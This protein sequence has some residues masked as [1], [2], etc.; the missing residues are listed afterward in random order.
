MC[1]CAFP[2]LPSLG[3]N[4]ACPAFYQVMILALCAYLQAQ[5]RAPAY[6]SL[7]CPSPSTYKHKTLLFFCVFTFH[8]FFVSLYALLILFNQKVS[9]HFLAAAHVHFLSHPPSCT[10]TP[11][12]S[13]PLPRQTRTTR[14][15]YARSAS[16]A[17]LARMGGRRLWRRRS[18]SSLSS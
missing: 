12:Y 18:S 4:R 11:V 7:V 16:R 10:P 5:R 13:L 6:V 3:G 2:F 9:S 17:L 1:K 8:S 14:K 15:S